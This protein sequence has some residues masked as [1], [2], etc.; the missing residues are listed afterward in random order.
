MND[1][2]GEN[3]S[4]IFQELGLE[5]N[6]SERVFI[7]DDLAVDLYIS[8]HNAKNFYLYIDLDFNQLKHVCRDLQ[9][10]LSSKLVNLIKQSGIDCATIDLSSIEKNSTLIIGGILPH[11]FSDNGVQ[12]I[13][14]VE[15]DPYFFKKQLLYVT[16]N[17]L[18]LMN[19]KFNENKNKILGYLN[20]IISNVDLFVSYIGDTNVEYGYVSKLYEKIPLLRLVSDKKQKENLSENIRSSLLDGDISKLDGF[21][22]L[23]AD[24]INDWIESVC[25]VEEHD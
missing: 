21:L 19:S 4:L 22:A 2:L 18:E 7:R 12:S 17:Q 6:I 13:I 3:I 11:D 16:E 15:E 14:D 23:D 1:K 8:V 9:I 20:K 5:V 10:S 24:D 25:K